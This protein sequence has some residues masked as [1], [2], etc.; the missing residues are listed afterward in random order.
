MDNN[1]SLV[2]KFIQ[3]L[4]TRFS[5]KDLGSL[6]YF[7]DIEVLPTTTS[8]FLSQQKYIHDILVYTKMHGAKAV[9]MP[10]STT[11]SLMLYDG[12]SLTDSTPFRCF[13][14]GLQYLSLTRHDISFAVKKLSQFMHSPS[15]T[16]WQALKRFLRYLKGTISFGLHLCRCPLWGTFSSCS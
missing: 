16:H 1:S 10:F 6:H 8:L 14:S 15:E 9:S 5:I 11:D 4:A 7:L 12:S 2:V 3:L 13:V